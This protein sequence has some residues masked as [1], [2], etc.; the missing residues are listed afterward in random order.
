[1]TADSPRPPA[2]FESP[3]GDAVRKAADELGV[4]PN[5]LPRSVAVIMDGNGRWAESRDLPRFEGHRV[6]AESVDEL[7]TLA[8]RLGIECLTLYCFSTENWKRPAEE[9]S[10][11]FELLECYITEQTP[12]ILRENLRFRVI[13]D[14]SA[15]PG[16]A[17]VRLAETIEAARDNTGTTLC[18]AL[19]YGSRQEITRAVRSL[20]E[21]VAAGRLNAADVCDEA[22]SVRLDTSAMPDPDLLI[23]TAGEMRLSNFLLWQISY[24][25]L[26]VTDVR[27]P[28][29]RAAAF[30]DALRSFASRDRR[31]G[32]LNKPVAG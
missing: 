3:P 25:E 30:A 24:A 19:N 18:L 27:W 10:L 9:Q 7:V 1:M 29:F 14:I 4:D 8:T 20:A 16:S 5:R 2:A 17:R 26:Y 21:D 28:D 23:R 11:L 15:L 6:G 22:I 31:F 32:G 13:G 12:K